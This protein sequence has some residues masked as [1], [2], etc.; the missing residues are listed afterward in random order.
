[1]SKVEA[2]KYFCDRCK[3]DCTVDV[4]INSGCFPTL[5]HNGMGGTAPLPKNC[6]QI[7]LCKRCYNEFIDWTKY[8]V[9]EN[10]RP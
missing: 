4:K 3:V 10:G 7:E 2:V 5:Y 8:K 6:H 1:M 9:T